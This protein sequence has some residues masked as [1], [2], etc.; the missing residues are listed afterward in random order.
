[1]LLEF[2]SLG[3]DLVCMVKELIFVHMLAV[4]F[5]CEYH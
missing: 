4:S 3:L 5:S 2:S 1:M